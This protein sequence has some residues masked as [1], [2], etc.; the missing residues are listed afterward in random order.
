MNTSELLKKLTDV[1]DEYMEDQFGR[2]KLPFVEAIPICAEF[3]VV[4]IAQRRGWSFVRVPTEHDGFMSSALYRFKP[5]G[6]T[7][8]QDQMLKDVAA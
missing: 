6:W 4:R 2:A 3:R 8:E 1:F 5:P 7:V